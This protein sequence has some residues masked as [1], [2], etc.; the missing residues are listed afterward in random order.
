MAGTKKAP[1]RASYRQ[2]VAR[3]KRGDSRRQVVHDLQ[4]PES[5]VGKVSVHAG[6][7]KPKS[8]ENRKKDVAI[9][10]A[11]LAAA[12]PKKPT[13]KKAAARKR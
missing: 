3:L 13:A 9:V 1:D 2:I 12:A 7:V 6:I 10:E 5:V 4:L 11:W 8:E